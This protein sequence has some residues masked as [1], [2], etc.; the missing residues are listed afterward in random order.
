M[1]QYKVNIFYSRKKVNRHDNGSKGQFNKSV[2][3]GSW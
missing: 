3:H 1:Y 2:K